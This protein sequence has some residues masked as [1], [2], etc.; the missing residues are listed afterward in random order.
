MEVLA[1]FTCTM[2][3][4][5]NAFFIFKESIE[6]VFEEA[7]EEEHSFKSGASTLLSVGAIVTA[8]CHYTCIY[9]VRHPAFEHVIRWCSSSWIQEQMAEIS[10][11]V[12]HVLP[13]MS[14]LLLPRVNPLSLIASVGL[15]MITLTKLLIDFYD[16]HVADNITAIAFALMLIY[17]WL[18]MTKYSG[19]IL[20]QSMPPHLITQ[21]D[22]IINEISTL[23]GVL[24]VKEDT[25]WTCGFQSLVGTV[26]IR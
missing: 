21:R 14:V 13:F 26:K 23:D 22:K 17:T 3:A 5:L 12:C 15:A 6:H 20:L 2:L 8:I 10:Q 7:E 24:E 1:V 9:T 25:F 19:R 4:Q 11:S 18:P 16:Y